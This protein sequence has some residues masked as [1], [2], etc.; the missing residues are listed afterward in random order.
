MQPEIVIEETLPPLTEGSWFH[1]KKFNEKN[2]T[3]VGNHFLVFILFIKTIKILID[4]LV[5][6]S[7]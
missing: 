4:L 2:I 1:E 7:F 6:Q 3:T 5:I